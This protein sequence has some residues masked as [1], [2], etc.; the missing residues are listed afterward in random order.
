MRHAYGMCATTGL[1]KSIDDVFVSAVWE[2]RAWAA[3]GE[4][5]LRDA[6]WGLVGP[7]S[8]TE[9]AMPGGNNSDQ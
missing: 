8:T 2:A 9:Q 1:V 4:E 3:S 6:R 5:A 7:G